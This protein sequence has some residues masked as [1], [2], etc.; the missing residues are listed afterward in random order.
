M[1]NRTLLLS[2]LVLGL[3]ALGLAFTGREETR[4]PEPSR[5]LVPAELLADLRAIEVTTGGKTARIERTEG[6]W[7]VPSRFGLP[8]D[9]D[10]RLRPLLQS[11]RNAKSLGALTAD[12][13]RIARL[14]FD[15]NS[16]RLEGAEGK[17]WS[18]EFGRTTDNGVGSAVRLTGAKEA[19]ATNFLGYLEGDPANWINPVL[20]AAKPEE[21]RA[22]A[23]TFPD[24]SKL[25]V[26]RAKVG[27]PLGGVEPRLL[28]AAEDLL[29]Y[30]VTV[31]ATDAIARGDAAANAA[32]A[33]PL[34]AEMTLWSGPTVTL[35]LARDPAAKPGEP[36]RGWLTVSHSDPKHPLNRQAE[37]ALFTSPPWL[38][39]QVP[40]SA[41]EFAKRLDPPPAD[42]TPPGQAEPAIQLIPAGR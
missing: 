9:A 33:K 21:V 11:L 41:T 6:G 40:A 3:M 13:R 24:G 27:E 4:A 36:P 25:R 42:A 38:A 26:E 39:E 5:P 22:L 20:F 34:V 10:N 16:V 1:R 23:L 29:N 12:P 32:L 30:I 28:A 18:A 2:T 19:M 35:R 14:G 37:T 31:R 8:V 7:V 15:G 17:V